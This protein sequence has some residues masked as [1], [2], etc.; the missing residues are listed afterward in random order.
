MNCPDFKERIAEFVAGELA[1]ELQTEMDAHEQICLTCRQTVAHWREMESL[2]RSSLPVQNPPRSFFLPLP[3]RHASWL[4]TARLWFGFAS[5]ATVTAC[6]LLFALLR[7]SVRVDHSQVSVDFAHARTESAAV[8]ASAVTAEQV[9]GLVQ[10]A[11]EEV[12]SQKS[13]TL[14]GAAPSKATPA[15][16]EEANRMNQLAVQVQMLKETQSA[17]WQQVQQHGLY[18]Q[19]SWRGPSDQLDMYEKQPAVQP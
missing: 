17:L 5:M 3:P 1:P 15:A 18:L 14:P 12:T 8:P 6:L 9:Q 13:N 11:L 4:E 7:P 19:S 10:Q 2:L 16:I